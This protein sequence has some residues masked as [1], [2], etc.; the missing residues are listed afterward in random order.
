MSA[1]DHFHDALALSIILSDFE[2]RT[3]RLKQLVRLALIY[4]SLGMRL[5]E[6]ER[7]KDKAELMATMPFAAWRNEWKR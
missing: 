2:R 1:G 7:G 5:E 6:Q 4:P 3:L